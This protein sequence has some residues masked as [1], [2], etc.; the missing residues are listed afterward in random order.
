M[1]GGTV[2]TTGS[3]AKDYIL[4]VPGEAFTPCKA[5]LVGV[6]GAAT[7]VTPGGVTR[8]LVPLQTGYNPVSCSMVVVAG[9]VA[10]DIWRLADEV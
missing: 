2:R 7:L 1:S 9:L 3:P 8:T 10:S 6:G 5:L 4:V